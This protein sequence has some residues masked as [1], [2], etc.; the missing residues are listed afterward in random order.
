[1][2]TSLVFL[3]GS[4]ACWI[5]SGDFYFVA[6]ALDDPLLPANSLYPDTSETQVSVSKK[7]HVVLFGTYQ[8]SL[9]V[10]AQSIKVSLTK[11]GFDIA[12]T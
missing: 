7:T 12:L 10:C 2:L 3:V 8:E 6:P 5:R 9:I 4:G 11:C 1:M